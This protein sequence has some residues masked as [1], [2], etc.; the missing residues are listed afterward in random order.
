MMKRRDPP[1]R[2]KQEMDLVRSTCIEM[3]GEP[4]QKNLSRACGRPQKTLRNWFCGFR[5]WPI[6]FASELPRIL[7]GEADRL[8][9][10]AAD[11]RRKAMELERG[12]RP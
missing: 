10:K 3:W 1:E 6:G 2:A 7:R 11:L 8:V 12:D 5:S 4:W 9:E